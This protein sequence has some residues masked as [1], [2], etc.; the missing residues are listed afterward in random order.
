MLLN[1]LSELLVQDFYRPY[2]LPVTQPT[3]SKHQRNVFCK[4]H[5][6]MKETFTKWPLAAVAISNHGSMFKVTDGLSDV[7]TRWN[8]LKSGRTNGGFRNGMKQELL[9]CSTKVH[10]QFYHYCTPSVVAWVVQVPEHWSQNW[11]VKVQLAAILLRCRQVHSSAFV[12]QQCN[13]EQAKVAVHC[14][15]E[16]KLYH[17]QIWPN[18][19]DSPF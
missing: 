1:N 2:A 17:D 4:V 3:A 12:I 5:R 7:H 18:I 14:D 16:D 15:W 8:L 11:E 9:Q 10:H 6:S 13:L 19:H